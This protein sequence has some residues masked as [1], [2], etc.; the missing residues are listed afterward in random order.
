ISFYNNIWSDPTGT[1][2][3]FCTAPAGETLSRTLS[4]N[5]YWNG[6]NPIPVEV[7]ESINYTDDAERIVGDPR[8]P[9]QATIVPPR[10]NPGTGTFNGGATTIR[11]VFVNLVTQYGVP[12]DGGAGIDAAQPAQAPATDILGNSRSLDAGPDI[13]A[14]EKTGLPTGEPGNLFLVY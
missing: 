6:A 13:G 10:W 7:N 4:R 3:D 14:L 1:M 11:D 5:L 8:L 12:A 2:E 9:E